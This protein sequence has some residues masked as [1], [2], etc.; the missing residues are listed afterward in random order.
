MRI[1]S[2]ILRNWVIKICVIL[3]IFQLTANASEHV[4]TV[5]YDRVWECVSTTD[6]NYI[7]KYLKFDGTEHIQGKTYHRLV[8]FKKSIVQLDRNV[9]ECTYEYIYNINEIEG[10]MREEDGKI[11]TLT[12]G[13][14][15]NNQYTGCVFTNDY[16]PSETNLSE[17]LV[18]DFS[19]N[20]GDT[21]SAFSNVM[22]YGELLDFQVISKSVED[23]DGEECIKM[24]VD[25]TRLADSGC[26]GYEI[27]EGIGPTEYG[28]LN[29]N[30]FYARP[31]T[32]WMYNYINRVYDVD[33]NLI[34]K[35]KDCMDY[36]LPPDNESLVNSF[37][38]TPNFI[39]HQNRLSFGDDNSTN[40]IEI[41]SM[42][43]SIIKSLSGIG[44][45]SI[46]TRDLIPG[47][48]VVKAK[49][50]GNIVTCRKFMVK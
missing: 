20:K 13:S 4:S 22:N 49:S 44:R 16:S 3:S 2:Y 26:T 21:Y 9:D 30:E 50:N 1:K 36:I 15:N 6:G 35:A 40:E 29:Y 31:L 28:C 48:Y 39:T 8:T 45:I 17:Q 19:L 27:I 23:I 12:E 33:G 41:C 42:N 24:L 7:V 11:Y 38:S 34:F 18:Y 43:G 5:R 37:Q 25:Q 32:L 46:S 47:I 10:Y 14:R